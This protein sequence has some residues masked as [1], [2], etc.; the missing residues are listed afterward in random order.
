MINNV[1]S[2]LF[3]WDPKNFDRLVK[4]CEN[5]PVTPYI[6][7]Y[8]PKT[9]TILEAGCGLGHFVKYLS[10]KKYNIEGI[11][12]NRKTVKASN[13]IVPDLIIKQGDVSKLFYTDNSISGYISLGVVEHLIEGPEIALKE[14]YRVLKPGSIAIITVPCF[15]GLRRIKHITGICYLEYYLRRFYYFILKKNVDWLYKNNLINNYKFDY[16]FKR[17]PLFGNFFEYRFTKREFDQE[18]IKVGFLIIESIPYDFFAGLYHELGGIIFP[19]KHL[20][21]P[22][23]FVKFLNYIFSFIP[24]FHNHSYLCVVKK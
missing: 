14:A 8:L 4:L 1:E 13:Q 11:E 7:K 15:N 16:K 3:N 12:I 10:N 6:L 21:K 19:L 9:G 2:V 18:L 22:N 23:F 24:Y 5:N 20:D 17:W